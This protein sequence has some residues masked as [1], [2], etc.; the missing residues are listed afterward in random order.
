M[1]FL[2][3]Y[4]DNLQY[5]R[6]LGAEFAAEFPKIAGR[7]NLSDFECE[8]PYVERILE[9]TA[10]LS[11]RVEKKLD[12]GYHNF[13]E[14]ILNSIAPS[15]LYP[16]PSGAVL[17]LELNYGD[18]Q[19]QKG[20]SLPDGTFFDAPIPTINSLCRFS[21]IDNTPLLP[22]SIIEEQYL[23]RELTALGIENNKA[24]SA[25]KLKFTPAGGE[26]FPPVD[27]ILAYANMPD[28]DASLLQRQ[29]I[30]DTIDVYYRYDEGA[31]K[32]A[33]EVRF[34]IP[35]SYGG[36]FLQEELKNNISGLR[37]LQDFLAYPAFFKFIS[38]ENIASIFKGAS[39]GQVE[40]V[41]LFKRKEM[42]LVSNIKNGSLKLN[43]VPVLNMFTK[44]SDR[45]AVDKDKFE[46]HIIPD[47]TSPRDYEV[48]NIHALEFFNERNETLFFAYNFYDQDIL[49][50]IETRNFLSPH[51]RKSLF[52]K[53]ASQ[54]SS[55][56]GTEMFVSF[57]T[58]TSK[59]EQMY[60][61]AADMIC[62]NRDLPLLLNPESSLKSNAAYI[63]NAFFIAMPSRP[64]YPLINRGDSADYAKLSHI[65]FNL[66]SMLWQ[67]GVMP[68]KMFQ[69]MILNYRIR[70]DEETER[71]AGGI[72]SLETEP[73][74]FRFIER[75]TIFFE[76]GW[77][78]SFTLDETAYAGVGYYTFGYLI[79]EILKT[80]TPIN[81]LL[82][83]EFH[84][85]QSGLIG[86]WKTFEDQ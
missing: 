71:I 27:K 13:L 39:L 57:S 85:Q 74:M 21:S 35:M 24:V 1:D 55:Y 51:R 63:E 16:I 78:V 38:I 18:E 83:I 70:S 43:C 3:Y 44:R 62:T 76:R 67:D 69:A 68:L 20:T 60:Q 72:V 37:L 29:L 59:A 82:S 49:R 25:L 17:E 81:T 66:S 12:E 47:R 28:A 15:V 8:D 26:T 84:T 31:F 34:G 33:Q 5:I 75:R 53:K 32:Q 2:D 22:L 9:G 10:F 58:Q 11:A 30:N 52:D 73:T 54:R 86:A 64:K 77:K 23:T 80:F 19:A 50:G 48:V 4:R 42:S 40:L 6:A 36:K 14:S 7:L 61:F 56:T 79:G 45:I 46:Y 65:L 41:I